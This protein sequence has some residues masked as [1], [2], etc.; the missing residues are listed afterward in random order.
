[1]KRSGQATSPV[2][3]NS[4]AG[5]VKARGQPQLNKLLTSGVK[6]DGLLVMTE[7]GNYLGILDEMLVGPKGELLAYEISVG[8]AADANHGKCLL[9]ADEALTVG[10]DVATFPDGVERLA[11]Q[12]LPD[13]EL[14]PAQALPAGEVRA[15]QQ[16]HAV[17]AGGGVESHARARDATA[18]HRHVELVVCER[19]ERLCAF[20]HSP[21]CLRAPPRRRPPVRSARAPR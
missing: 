3:I 20:D 4:L 6:L 5:L 21:Q 9:P 2:T 19:G 11:S 15:L 18:D 7:G 14:E 1:M 16:R 12:P 10:R 17:T 13:V 8:F